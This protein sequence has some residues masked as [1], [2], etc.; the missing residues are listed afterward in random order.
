MAGKTFTADLRKFRDL[1]AKNMLYVA[2]Q[3]IQ[4][5][6]EAAQTPQEGI[7]RGATS[8]VEGKIPVARADLIRSLQSGVGTPSGPTGE[9]SYA[10]VIQGMELGDVLKFE[11]T[12]AHSLPMEL[13]F[14]TKNGRRVPGRHFVGRNASRFSEFVANRV[15]EVRR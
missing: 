2:S 5:V 10:A 1:T 9:T 15:A 11:W 8:F 12:A 14:T 6:V 13:G 4:D 7:T 3:S